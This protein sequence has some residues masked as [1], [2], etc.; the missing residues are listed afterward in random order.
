MTTFT[1]NLQSIYGFFKIYAKM[2]YFLQNSLGGGGRGFGVLCI[3]C[4]DTA[5]LLV[6][7]KLCMSIFMHDSYLCI[8]VQ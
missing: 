7:R 3:G 6:A 5:V 8:L 2:Y 1:G 4:L